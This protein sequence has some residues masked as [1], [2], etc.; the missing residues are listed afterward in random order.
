MATHACI[1]ELDTA[2]EAPEKIW[3]G[4][5]TA[6]G[7]L[8]RTTRSAK[9]ASQPLQTASYMYPAPRMT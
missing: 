5:S 4:K 8:T 3:A 7:L 1:V 9:Q 2:Q 6:E